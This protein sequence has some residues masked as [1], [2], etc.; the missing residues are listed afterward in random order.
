MNRRGRSG[1]RARSTIM[2]THTA[3]KAH[4]VPELARAAISSS[5][6]KPAMEA[7]ITAVR[8]VTATGAPR[9]LT[10]ASDSGS[11]RSRAM[12]KKMRLWP[13]MKARITVGRAT[14]AA[15]AISVAAPGRPSPRSTAARGSALSA[16]A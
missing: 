12:A 6:R 1:S 14:I 3:T 2:H 13:Y 5:G 10:V 16:R 7:A 9:R 15:A 8:I 4:R 11:M